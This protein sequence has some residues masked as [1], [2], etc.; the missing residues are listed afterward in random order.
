MGCSVHEPSSGPLD[1]EAG[2]E[3]SSLQEG[4]EGKEK[5][6]LLSVGEESG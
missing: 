2:E 3:G 1:E 6:L 4:G 5:G